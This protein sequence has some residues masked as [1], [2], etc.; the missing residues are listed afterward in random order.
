MQ[1]S[2]QACEVTQV[3]QHSPPSGAGPS[4]SSPPPQTALRS[5][6]QLPNIFARVVAL[7]VG[8]V[9]ELAAAAQAAV[10]VVLADGFEVVAAV[11]E[12]LKQPSSHWQVAP[13]VNSPQRPSQLPPPEMSS[14][15][16]S[17]LS[18]QSSAS[19]HSSSHWQSASSMNSPQRSGV[20]SSLNSTGGGSFFGGDRDVLGDDLARARVESLPGGVAQVVG[21][22]GLPGTRTPAAEWP[23]RGCARRSSCS[24]PS[25]PGRCPRWRRDGLR[26]CD[27]WCGTS[28]R[29]A[30][31]SSSSV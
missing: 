27:T 12:L 20:H 19:T 13:L 22:H 17:K 14:Q 8:A 11:A 7:A 4:P 30:E 26:G 15:T 21:R 24:P 6:Q 2:P 18:Q 16:A 3:R 5:S 29:C 1:A 23:A 9:G 10:G 31:A 25:G 28:R